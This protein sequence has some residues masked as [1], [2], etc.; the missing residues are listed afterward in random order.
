M[1]V[2]VSA[3]VPVFNSFGLCLLLRSTAHLLH[4]MTTYPNFIFL[5]FTVPAKAFHCCYLNFTSSHSLP[6]LHPLLQL[7]DCD[8]FPKPPFHHQSAMEEAEAQSWILRR[9]ILLSLLTD[10]QWSGWAPVPS[11]P[12]P[13]VVI[14][15]FSL[16]ADVNAWKSSLIL[17]PWQKIKA[18]HKPRGQRPKARTVIMASVTLNSINTVAGGGSLCPKWDPRSNKDSPLSLVRRKVWLG[19]EALSGVIITLF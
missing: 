5:W 2:H 18:K 3:W 12:Q 15:D 14:P 16:A 8:L 13:E 10:A 17:R 1:S 19:P 11:L 6:S 7:T 4:H 9:G